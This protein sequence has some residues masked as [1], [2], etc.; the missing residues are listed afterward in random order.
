MTRSSSGGSP[1]RQ[2]L[3]RVINNTDTARWP[4]RRFLIVVRRYLI[5]AA[6]YNGLVLASAGPPVARPSRSEPPVGSPTLLLRAKVDDGA[7]C[8]DPGSGGRVA[9]VGDQAG[10]AVCC[11]RGPKDPDPI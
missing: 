10:H 1:T 11:I 2:P 6:S 5:C 8:C 9:E 3:P 4:T 7:S